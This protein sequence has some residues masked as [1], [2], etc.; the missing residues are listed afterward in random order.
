MKK[1]KVG[2]ISAN[3][4]AFAHLPGWRAVPG[5]EVVGICTSRRATADAAAARFHVERPFWDAEAMAEDPDIDNI[6]CVT[7]P[8]IRYL[9]VKV[10]SESRR[11]RVGQQV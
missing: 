8:N 3:W 9:Q 6:D 10:G 11:D 4:G 7:R 1:L 5:V 2:I